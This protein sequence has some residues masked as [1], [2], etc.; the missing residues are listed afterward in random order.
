M[1]AMTRL[2]VILSVAAAVGT[3]ARAE[4]PPCT[5]EAYRQFDFWI[6]RWDVF[7]TQSGKP[8]GH[9]LIERIYGG[10]ALRENWSEP[11]FTGGSLNHYSSEDGRWRQTWTDSAGAWRE[12]VGGIQDGKM[13]LVWRFPSRKAVGGEGQVRMTFTPGPGHVVRQYSDKSDD[14]GLTWSL[15]Y[16]YT[17][18]PAREGS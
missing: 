12:F 5:A 10:C 4:Q 14:G 15:R 3:A 16:D 17:Y 8:A 2:L 18:R 1:R 6:G 9:S 7:E 13:V 11:G